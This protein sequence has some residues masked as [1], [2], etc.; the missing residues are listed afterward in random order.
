MPRNICMGTHP[1]VCS[2]LL[3]PNQVNVQAGLVP[4]GLYQSG[5]SI[6]VPIGH[7][8]SLQVTHWCS[9]TKE[10]SLHRTVPGT[11]LQPRSLNSTS[12]CLPPTCFAAC[13]PSELGLLC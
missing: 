4:Q 13:G 2:T 9:E 5:S 8:V 3:T 6:A 1:S 10:E 7:A 12:I 11:R